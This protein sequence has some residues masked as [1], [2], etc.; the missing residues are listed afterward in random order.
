MIYMCIY[1]YV[2]V[3]K[4]YFTNLQLPFC[5]KSHSAVWKTKQQPTTIPNTPV[6]GVYIRRVCSLQ[7]PCPFHSGSLETTVYTSAWAQHNSLCTC[8]HQ[9][10]IAVMSD[11]AKDSLSRLLRHRCPPGYGCCYQTTRQW[12]AP[13]SGKWYQLQARSCWQ[14]SLH[15]AWLQKRD[16]AGYRCKHPRRCWL[17]LSLNAWSAV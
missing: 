2:Y 15:T 16:P 7:V 4:L 8:L 1:V 5:N 6:S 12:L 3:S 9:A 11:G 13:A 14:R 17:D 10:M